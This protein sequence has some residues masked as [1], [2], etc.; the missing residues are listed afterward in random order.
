[1]SGIAVEGD[2]IIQA[3]LA[4]ARALLG[5]SHDHITL[6]AEQEWEDS[7]IARRMLDDVADRVGTERPSGVASVLCPPAVLRG[8]GATIDKLRRGW[9]F[10]GRGR[11]MGRRYSGWRDT[12]FERLT[13]RRAIDANHTQEIKENRLLRI[14]E[15]I[16]LWD[17]NVASSLYAHT[18]LPTDT[19]RTRG[20]PCL[21]YVQFR[22]FDGD[23]IGVTGLYRSHD[24]LSKALGNLIGLQRLARFVAGETGRRFGRVTVISLAP[25]C[26]GGKRTLRRYVDDIAEL[27]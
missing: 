7:A 22:V 27:V 1:M 25:I 5:P 11:Q 6:T 24:Y 19:L 21:Q 2:D 8:E 17:T 16:N 18:D 14:V 3:W 10:L 12:Y 20:A 26:E 15:K 13:G 9:R 23:R 4:G